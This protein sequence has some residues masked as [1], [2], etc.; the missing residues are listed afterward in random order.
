MPKCKAA[1]SDT[2][3]PKQGRKAKKKL[4]MTMVSYRSDGQNDYSV[5]DEHRYNT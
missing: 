2:A 5:D 4:T 3:K 1:T